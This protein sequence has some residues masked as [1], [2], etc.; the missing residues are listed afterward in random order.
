M[1]TNKEDEAFGG[2]EQAFDF[3]TSPAGQEEPKES[4]FEVDESYA[5]EVD[6]EE[7]EKQIEDEKKSKSTKKSKEEEP[8]E[9]DENDEDGE[10]ED[11]NEVDEDLEDAEITE[12]SEEDE[13]EE[14]DEGDEDLD[15]KD[16]VD[17]F[18]DLFSEEL[19]W[20]VDEEEKPKSIKELLGLM[21][22]IIEENSAPNY[23]SEDIKKLDDFVKNGG[24]IKEYFDTVFPKDLDLNSV[25]LSNG[26]IQKAVVKEHL[27]TLNYSDSKIERRLERYEEAGTLEEEA[28]EAVELLKEYNKSKEEKLLKETE[29]RNK[30]YIE[31][32]Q[33]FISNVEDTINS[34]DSIQGIPLSKKDKKEL[35]DYLF[36][37]NSDGKTAYQKDYSKDVKSI[38]TSAFFLKN[39]EKALNKVKS[40]ADSDATLKLKN[41]LKNKRK[42]KQQRSYQS[43][44]AKFQDALSSISKVLAKN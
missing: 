22:S 33:R 29:K 19:G 25:D 36:K 14:I 24:D 6:P 12:P 41:R 28:E 21:S 37:V 35:Y 26:D 5:H 7:L 16:I 3:I 42:P 30:A 15:E 18:F 2:F 20:E 17:P 4:G 1:S 23:A 13:D 11:E 27:K 34:L 44:G 8:E 43:E 31:E 40:K 38:I 10:I 9:I 32:Q 39:G